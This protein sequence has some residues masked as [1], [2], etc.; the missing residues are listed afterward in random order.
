[1][2]VLLTAVRKIVPF[3]MTAGN[4]CTNLSFLSVLRLTIT[5][6]FFLEYKSISSLLF[7]PKFISLFIACVS[8][9][10]GTTFVCPGLIF[11]VSP[12]Y[13]FN[14]LIKKW[15]DKFLKSA[16]PSNSY[17]AFCPMYRP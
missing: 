14:D 13:K 5:F 8:K 12:A 11:I 7:S 16:P 3:D 10:I 15:N 9:H 2:S 6:S 4:V 1:M 17:I